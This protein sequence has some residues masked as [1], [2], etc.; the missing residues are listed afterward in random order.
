MVPGD[1]V[2]GWERLESIF[3]D[4]AWPELVRQH[5]AELNVSG[6]PL[7]PDYRRCFALE[8]AG[9]FRAWTARA[10]TALVGY[11]AVFIQ[12]HLHY[13]STLHAVEDLFLLRPDCR[14]GMAG[15]RMFKGLI[16]AL[17]ELG[18]K[19]FICHSKNHWK[20]RGGRP[21]D[22]LFLRLGFL[23]TDT[24]WLLNMDKGNG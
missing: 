12:P 24:L 17:G 2:F 13:K 18:V 23:A 10:D 15:Y 16:A 8:E 7:D 14:N 4:P 19:R 9:V 1:P 21:I 6:C 5:Y 20:S 22:A 3:A 11:I